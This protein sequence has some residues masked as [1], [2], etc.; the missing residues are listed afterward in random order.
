MSFSV[1]T[2]I[3]S[4]AIFLTGIAFGYWLLRWKERNIRAAQSIQEKGL[5]EGYHLD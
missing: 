3:V 5:L 1:D 2:F 4:A